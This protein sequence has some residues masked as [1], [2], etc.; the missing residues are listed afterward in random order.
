MIPE[1]DEAGLLPPGVHWSDWGEFTDRFGKNPQRRSLMAGLSSALQDLKDAGCRTVYINGSFVTRKKSP[2]DYDACWEESGV[3]PL[4]L[5]PILLVFDAGRATQKA[6]YKGELFPVTSVANSS[7]FSFLEFF[8]TS[9]DDGRRKG[10]I[11]IDLR[12]LND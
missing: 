9:K 5:D 1:F 3:D 12:D 2:D 10:I 11:A 4:A 7:G 8:Q 6:K